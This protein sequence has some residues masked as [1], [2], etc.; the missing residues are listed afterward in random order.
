ML[1]RSSLRD[2]Y[3]AE[4]F[5]SEGNHLYFLNNT[6][7]D[8]FPVTAALFNLIH[9]QGY[10]DVILDF[11]QSN[12]LDPKF[13]LPLVATARS[14]RSDKVDFDLI[15]PSDQKAAKLIEN[16]NWAHLITP[17]RFEARDNRNINHLSA[18][19]YMNAR[20]Q[21]DAVDRSM[22]IILQSIGGLDRSRLKAL[23]W[24]LNEITDNVLVHSESPLGGIVQ[25]VSY[26]KRQLVEF[27]V[28]DAGIGIPRS[29]RSGRPELNDDV[30]ALRAA[31]KK[32]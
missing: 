11:S 31:S 28:C 4:M 12:F 2:D 20:E 18:I 3:P 14:Y 17:E 27:Y 9:K 10:K 26:T 8:I 22:N 29:L 19:Q 7:D 32:V 5:R 24:S 13:M 15:M 23:E 25:V 21:F 16:T 1:T 6:A 30:R